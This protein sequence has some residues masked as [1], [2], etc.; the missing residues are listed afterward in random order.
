MNKTTSQN[1]SKR[2]KQY[3]AL[4]VAL[5]GVASSSGQIIYHPNVDISGPSDPFFINLNPVDGITPGGVADAIPDFEIL[6][7]NNSIPSAAR[8]KLE[9]LYGNS[10]IANS[11][12][13]VYASALDSGFAISSANLNWNNG[14]SQFMVV[15][16]SCYGLGQ[17]CTATGKYLGLKFDIS[18]NTH[19]GWAKLDMDASTLTWTLKE[20]AFNSVPNELINAG[21]TVL[22]TEDNEFSKV[23]IV[24]SNKSI[25]LY[26]LTQPT[27]YEVF[28]M[29]GQSILNGKTST[30]KYIIEAN[31]LS[32]GLYILVLQDD[33]TNA[34]FRKKIVL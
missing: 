13:F 20:F 2:L 15:Y 14:D 12:T 28:N 1:L 24:S 11:T 23:K 19:Y 6:I 8:I 26:N 34:V 25:T 9:T 31:T 3:G 29:S 27:N 18:G 33:K 17:W 30:N 32:N 16:S 5:A 4:T 7:S 22:S 10:A 21:Q